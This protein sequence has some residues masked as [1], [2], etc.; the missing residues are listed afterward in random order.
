M[1]KNYNNFTFVGDKELVLSQEYFDSYN[2]W[3]GAMNEWLLDDVQWY[4]HTIDVKT[5]VRCILD[6]DKSLPEDYFNDFD[7]YEIADYASELRLI[8]HDSDYVLNDNIIVFAA[9]L[10]QCEAIWNN[11]DKKGGRS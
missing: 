11:A 5:F 3:L 10:G 8:A 7:I 4:V 1:A 6:Y 9:S 2:E